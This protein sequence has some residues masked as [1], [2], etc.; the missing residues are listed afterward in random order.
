MT[1]RGMKARKRRTAGAKLLSDRSSAPGPE[2]W[3]GRDEGQAY[4][5]HRPGAVPAGG[6]GG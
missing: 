2:W 4:S 5:A 1:P 6:Q 3:R